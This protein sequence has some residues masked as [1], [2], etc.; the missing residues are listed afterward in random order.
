MILENDLEQLAEIGKLTL[1]GWSFEAC[2]NI[3]VNQSLNL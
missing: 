3:K 2:F 1:P